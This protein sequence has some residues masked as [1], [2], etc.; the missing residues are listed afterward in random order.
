MKTN[1]VK[2]VALTATFMVPVSANA[3]ELDQQRSEQLFTYANISQPSG[4]AIVSVS[5]NGTQFVIADALR[6]QVYVCS[7]TESRSKV[8]VICYDS[9]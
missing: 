5:S 8:N 6:K 1:L 2:I 9:E 3:K 7:V 4:P